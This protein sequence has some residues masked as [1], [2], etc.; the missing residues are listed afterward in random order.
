MKKIG[1]KKFLL[2]LMLLPT[3][4]TAETVVNEC[5]TGSEYGVLG[6]KYDNVKGV[7]QDDFKLYQMSCG[8]LN[9]GL[10]CFSLGFSY[11]KGKGVKQDDFKAV[12][13]SQKACGL[14]DGFGCA[15]LGALYED[16]RGIKQSNIKALEYYGKACDLKSKGGCQMYAELKRKMGV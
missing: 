2:A 11:A 7:K 10:A 13:F 3:F 1:F 16:G 4:V 9:N 15:L 6:C 8:L 14:N 5:Y 12:E